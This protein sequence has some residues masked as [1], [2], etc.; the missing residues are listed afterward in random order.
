MKPGGRSS[1]SGGVGGSPASR[2]SNSSPSG[3]IPS[4][5]SH[6]GSLIFDQ[7]SERERPSH[8]SVWRGLRRREIALEHD[9]QQLLDL[10]A[11]GL[12]AGSGPGSHNNDIDVISDTGS[13]TPTGTFYSTAT[14]RSRM[15]NSL[16][17]P[18]KSTPDGNIIP[19]RQP[20]AAKPP[21]LGSA[22]AGL[23]KT[24]SSLVELKQEED[25]HVDAALLD[26]K[27]ALI[28]LKKVLRQKN[29][30]ETELQAFEK[31]DEEPLGREIRDFSTQYEEVSVEI[32]QLEEKLVG[33]RN[34]RRSL[35]EKMEDARN[36]REAGLS[37]YRG[38]LKDA[39]TELINIMRHPPIRPLDSEFLQRSGGNSSTG[40]F[41]SPGGSE[42]MRLI[43]ERRTSGMVQA[44][45][46]SEVAILEQ[47][48]EQIGKEKEA[49]EEG[50]TVWKQVISI[51]GEFETKLRQLMKTGSTTI[52]TAT[53][54]TK[55]KEKEPTQEELMRD[56]LSQMNKIATDLQSFLE[57]AEE[58]QWNLLICAIGAELEAFREALTMLDI[59]V[60]G[61]TSSLGPTDD[62]QASPELKSKPLI[63]HEESDNE[64]PAD[65]LISHVVETQSS[66]D[67][68]Q[69]D[70]AGVLHRVDSENEVPL[71]FLAE[72]E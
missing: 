59:V 35:R 2:Q 21:S 32:R 60:N 71:E 37:G 55:G 41:E 72:H 29:G 47:R 52:T 63:Q 7:R 36:R 31:D 8:D 15:I 18:T 25:A 70:D 30:V 14:S 10:Q 20:K 5:K 67:S 56:Q 6:L 17:I 27:R 23:R 46:E 19:V 65:L 1:G 13:S 54:S 12:V 58:K 34:R 16:H 62:S 57:L 28:H 66:A 40:D 45:W 50:A 4:R 43:P 24:I 49:L 39:D 9:I 64:V 3:L 68:K 26:R 44:W 53:Q 48:R 33:L 38:A 51:V 42:F 11:T 69:S 61:E 22:R